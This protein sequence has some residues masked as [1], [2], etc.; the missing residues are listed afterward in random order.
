MNLLNLQAANLLN[1]LNPLNPL[2]RFLYDFLTWTR[3]GV[4][5]NPNDSRS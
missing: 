4:P 5:I 3:I 1:P 2:N